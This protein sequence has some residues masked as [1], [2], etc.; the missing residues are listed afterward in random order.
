[1]AGNIAKRPNGRWRARYR[2]EHGHEHARHFDRK[3]DAQHWLDQ[4]ASTVLTGMYV[5]PGA[6]KVT[7][8]Q[9]YKDWSKRQLWVPSTR[10]NADLATGSVPF[11]ELPLKSIRRSHVKAWVKTAAAE[12]APSTIKTRF[13]IVRSVFRAAVA[14][15]V[16]VADPSAGVVLPRRRKAEAAMRGAGCSW[17]TTSRCTTTPSPGGGVQRVPRRTWCRSAS[18]TCATSMPP[19]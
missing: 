4:V 16:I 3:V 9:F 15:R 10:P 6:G 1:M 19:A 2:D 5:D 7:F 13:V 14:D 11:A 17:W 12:W 8:G 18:T